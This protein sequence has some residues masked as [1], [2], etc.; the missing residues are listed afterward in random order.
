MQEEMQYHGIFDSHA[1]YDDSR[2]QEDREEIFASLPSLGVCGLINVGCNLESSR[3]ALQY[4]EQYDYVYAAVGYHPEQAA[5]YTENGIA[6]IREMLRRPKTVAIG[7]IGLDYYWPALNGSLRWLRNW[8]SP[9]LSIPGMLLRI[10]SKLL[11]DFQRF[12]EWCIAS[13]APQ[14]RQLLWSRW[15]FSSDLPVS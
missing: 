10:R 8:I 6:E 2:F 13:P 3:T 1:H 7:E 9:S 5:E 14:R 12:A 11:R 15:V 4:A